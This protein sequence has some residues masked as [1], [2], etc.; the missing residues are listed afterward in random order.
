MAC[1]PTP[2]NN[3]IT[4]CN[5]Y[6]SPYYY[7][8]P[9]YHAHI[10]PD[11]RHEVAPPP[12]TPPPRNPP[13]PRYPSP[14]TPLRTPSPCSPVP[15]GSLRLTHGSLHWTRG[16]APT[17]PLNNKT[18][19]VATDRLVCAPPCVY[20]PCPPNLPFRNPRTHPPPVS[21]PPVPLGYGGQLCAVYDRPK[22]LLSL[23][24]MQQ[25]NKM[26][27]PHESGSKMRNELF[28]TL[29]EVVQRHAALGIE[30]KMECFTDS[31][32]QHNP[33]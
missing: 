2:I 19:A 9:S 8:S 14:C 15:F 12:R 17:P 3:P 20:T 6:G 32:P 10:Q 28:P 7:G 13:P 22:T 18:P 21:P 1:P 23:A 31:D 11:S 24:P 4:V 33:C 26:H 16:P 29:S 25:D 5:E 27:N 30:M